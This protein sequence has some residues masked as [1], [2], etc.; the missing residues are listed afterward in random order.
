VFVVDIE[1][2]M[3]AA[4]HIAVGIEVSMAVVVDI[5]VGMMAA[6][7]HTAAG[8]EVADTEVAL[9]VR[10]VVEAVM[11]TQGDSLA[12]I[13]LVAANIVDMETTVEVD[14]QD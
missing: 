9:A 11:G 7:V 5:E 10:P 14:I 3:A 12:D 4:V 13:A 6:A 1:A 2:D 8:I